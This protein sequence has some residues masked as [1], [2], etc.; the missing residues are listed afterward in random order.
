M[1]KFTQFV[2][3]FWV[4][5]LGAATAICAGFVFLVGILMQAGGFHSP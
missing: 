1:G 3:Y 4:L 2:L 5:T